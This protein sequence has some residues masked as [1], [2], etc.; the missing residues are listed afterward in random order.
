VGFNE[1]NLHRDERIVLDLH[2]HWIMLAKGVVILVALTVFGAW[3]YWGWSPEGTTGTVVNVIT[4]VAVL[5]ALLY[6]LQRWIAWISTNF[7]VTTDRTIYREGIVSKRGIEIPHDRINTVFFNQGV[8]DRLLRA[9]TLTIES[10]GENGVQV[11]ENVR[12]PIAVQQALYQEMED[13]ENRKFDRV[14]GPAGPSSVADELSKLATLRDQGHLSESEFQTQK[15][16][17]LGQ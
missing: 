8:F 12:D 2:P 16:R 15:A 1:S 3:V 17:L 6:F 7:V 4:A 5:A 9:G 11:F 13:N 10:A 14:R